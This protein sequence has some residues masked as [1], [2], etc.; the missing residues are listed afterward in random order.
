MAY[1]LNNAVI[2]KRIIDLM[3]G[4]LKEKAATSRL[5]QQTFVS[6]IFPLVASKIPAIIVGQTNNTQK[7]IHFDDFIEDNYGQSELMPITADNDLVGNNMSRVNLPE[8]LNYDPRWPWD[9]SIGYPSGTDIVKT[10]F[11]SQTGTNFDTSINTGIIIEIPPPSQ[12]MPTSILYGF[13][14]EPQSLPTDPIQNIP[15]QI[16]G[17]GLYNIAVAL[18]QAQ[19][20]FYLVYSGSGFTGTIIQN[21]EP[22]QYIVNASG[23][24]PGLSGTQFKLSDVLWAGDQYLFKVTDNTRFLFGTYGGMYNMTISFDCIARTTIETQELADLVERFFVE[25][26]F[27]LWDQLGLELLDWAQGGQNQKDYI[28]EPFFKIPITV[29]LFNEWH[30][31]RGIDVI[32]GASGVGIPTTGYSGTYYPPGV[33]TA[34]QLNNPIYPGGLDNF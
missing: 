8:V 15:L 7:R 22:N 21:V 34:T 31:Y 30:E 26:K 27:D 13:D 10:I 18:N 14:K 9:D 5:Y 20:Q 25:R 23:L 16:S 33:Y 24:V 12:F 32:T 29:G 28:N 6:D 1:R 17:T 2:T 4:F 19:D 3:I 11:T